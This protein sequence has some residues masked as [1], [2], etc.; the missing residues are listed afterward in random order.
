[1]TLT[2]LGRHGSLSGTAR[3]RK[4]TASQVS[5]AITR[6]ER[7]L[8]MELILRGARGVALSAAAQQLI[9]A[10]EAFASR[11]REAGESSTAGST[12]SIAANSSVAD[13]MLPPLVSVL[14]EISLRCVELPVPLIRSF[15]AQH[16]FD[17]A[18]TTSL[19]GLPRSWTKTR[20]GTYRLGLLTSPRRAKELGAKPVSVDRIRGLPF[21]WPAFV[22]H[23]RWQDGE[24]GCPLPVTARRRG[25]AAQTKT[26]ALE[27]AARADQLVFSSILM[28]RDALQDGTLVEV[29]V[30]GWNVELELSLGCSESM[31]ASTQRAMVDSLRTT[32][33][34]LQKTRT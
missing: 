26:L 14:P 30:E 10:I 7:Q 29:S 5:R 34:A 23:G 2:A 33:S 9:P 13:L 19:T 18:L 1:M 15:A 21:V 12:L 4:V 3:E 20:I 22:D 24:D 8:G 31:L 27:L 16:L 28:A 6:L 32:L 25:H 11:L 17:A